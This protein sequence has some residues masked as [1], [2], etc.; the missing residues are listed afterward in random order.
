MH[1]EYWQIHD[2]I[3]A[4]Y[5]ISKNQF[6]ILSN[7]WSNKTF[8]D[9]HRNYHSFDG[10]MYKTAFDKKDEHLETITT[11]HTYKNKVQASS[12]VFNFPEVKTLN[13]MGYMN[14]PLLM[15]YMPLRY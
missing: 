4:S 10:D 12:S 2:N 8:K 11:I 15:A 14:T 6:N 13:Y 9:L 5:R 3:G 1:R 7:R